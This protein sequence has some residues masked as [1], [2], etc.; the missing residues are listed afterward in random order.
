MSDRRDIS[1]VLGVGDARRRRAI[2]DAL[3]EIATVL[4][5]HLSLDDTLTAAELLVPDVLVLDTHLGRADLAASCF[6]VQMQVP[7]T[8]IVAVVPADDERAYDALA[9]GAFSVV[10][11]RADTTE[12]I[13]AVR[14]AARGES[15]MPAGCARRL[16]ADA[17]RA[18]TEVHDPLVRPPV[19]TPTEHEVLT[20]LGEGRSPHDIAR[21]HD[22]TPRLVNLHA[23]Y[24]VA[25]AHLQRQRIHTR[26]TLAPSIR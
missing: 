1:V 7:A 18:K 20:R 15:V 8:R 10:L 19:L 6:R 2:R 3:D 22:V 16:L 17:V 11:E 24:A 12:L 4:S 26:D 9:Y 23:G 5:D 13:D 14:G 21:M 25:K